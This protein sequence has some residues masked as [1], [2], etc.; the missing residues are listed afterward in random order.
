MALMTSLDAE[1]RSRFAAD[2]PEWALDRE[3]ISRTVQLDGFPAAV[4]FVVQ[5]AFLAEA[6]DHHPDIDIRWNKVTLRLTTHSA[7]ALTSKDTALAEKIS[8]LA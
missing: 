1:A 3:E 4:A 7:G 8:A 5:V 2:H 6:A